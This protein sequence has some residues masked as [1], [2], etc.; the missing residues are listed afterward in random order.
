MAKSRG[1]DPRRWDQA[2][3]DG[4]VGPA[5]VTRRDLK[6]T[7]AIKPGTPGRARISRKT[8]VQGM[9]DCFGVP[10]VTCL[11][12]FLHCTQ[13]C[14]RASGIPCPLCSLRGR[15]RCNARAIHAA[16]MRTLVSLHVIASD[17]STLAPQASQGRRKRSNPDYFRGGILDC[18]V[19]FAP[20][21]DEGA[22]V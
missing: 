19:R 1:P 7:E 15:R 20:R 22:A 10:V 21:N 5:G 3:D 8:I 13:G 9:P 6:V 12:A 18:F 16:R 17:P 11:R 14:D 4:D 2:L